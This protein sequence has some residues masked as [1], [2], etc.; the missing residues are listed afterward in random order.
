MGRGWAEGYA[1]RVYRG[2]RITP[3]FRTWCR[4]ED[5]L[6]DCPV[7]DEEDYSRRCYAQAVEAIRQEGER[8][9]DGAD[10]PEIWAQ[11]VYRWLWE[12]RPEAIEDHAA[13]C[14]FS[15]EVLAEALRELGYLNDSG[16]TDHD[17]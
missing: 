10:L 2:K 5:R 8:L 7:L 12:H 11:E 3:A 9:I 1:I 15:E 16:E 6:R 13:G 4:I 14:G 17:R